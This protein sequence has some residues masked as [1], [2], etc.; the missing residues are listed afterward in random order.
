MG[1]HKLGDAV[2]GSHEAHELPLGRLQRGVRHHV[3]Q[4]D[5]EF[6]HVLMG[7]P[8]GLQHFE[9]GFAKALEA[10]QWGVRYQW[11]LVRPD[12]RRVSG[13]ADWRARW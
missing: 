1:G 3:E 13:W 5:V 6:T 8:L 9:A 4:A 12:S 10:W 11:H 2:A 7:R